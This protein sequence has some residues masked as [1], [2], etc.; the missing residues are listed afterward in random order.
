MA[1]NSANP[2]ERCKSSNTAG[3]RCS[4]RAGVS[5]Y[6]HIHDPERRAQ[7]ETSQ[8]AAKEARQKAWAKGGHLRQVLEVIQRTCRAKGWNA[9]VTSKDEENWRYATV[10][11]ER[12]VKAEYSTEAVSVVF[13]VSVNGG[14][15]VSCQPTSSRGHGIQDLHNSILDELRCL[16]WLTPPR[17][18]Q[19]AQPSEPKLPSATQVLEGLIRRFPDAARQ[20]I[21]RHENRET[22]TI[23]DEYDV[24]DFLYALLK[25]YFEDVRAE[26][27]APSY[28][29]A[30]S[31]IDFL[32]KNEK[33]A[34]EAKMTNARLKDKKVGEQLIIDIKRYQSHS[35][36]NTLLC[37]VYD[38]DHHI[39][40]PAG[41]M[42]DLSRKHDD[43]EVRVFV[44]PA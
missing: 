27:C 1:P 24:Q 9:S 4:L 39:G 32:L 40:N 2:D 23:R 17:K 12:R 26:E 18:G 38:P 14:V 43:L 34:I 35:D 11:A 20:L 10:T 19:P 3:E 16:P 21:H 13:D 28:A 42:K 33:I 44:V 30:S 6:C 29:G 7:R 5:G 25:A 31:R 8:R 37:I 15:K 22:L 41:L 36:C